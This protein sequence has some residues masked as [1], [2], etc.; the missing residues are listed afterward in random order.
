MKKGKTIDGEV[1]KR[2]QEEFNEE[3]RKKTD[4]YKLE[5]G[6]QAGKQGM[7]EDRIIG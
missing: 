1:M 3:K 6:K 5:G 2:V 4:G 7:K